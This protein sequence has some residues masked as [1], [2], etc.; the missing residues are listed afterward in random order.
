MAGTIARARLPV[1]FAGAGEPDP[2][3]R[4]R[5]T[6]RPDR[7]EAAIE[8]LPGVGPTIARRLARLGLETV[9]D[10]LWQRPR[11][12]EE[13][14]PAKRICDLFG[15]EEAV[16]EGVVRSAT[17]RR[18]GR[19]KIL[20][21]RVADGTGEIKATWFNQPWLESKLV[22]GTPV[23]VRGRA[24]RYGFAV[25][26]YDLDG[27]SET[28]DF[29]P[30]YPASEDVSQKKLRELRAHALEL[31]RDVGEL[32]PASLLGAE[33]L[34][35]RA[36]A[37]ASVH[38]P[39]TLAEAEMGR[40]RL[41][42]EELLVLR[43]ALARTASRRE[44]ASAVPL[45]APGELLARYRSS[46]PFTLTPDQERSIVEID[47]DLAPDDA[48]ATAAAGRGRL[49]QDG[50]RPLC[51]AARGGARTPG[52]AD[53]TDGDARRAALPH[54]R[55]ALRTA[56]RPGQPADELAAGEGARGREAGDRV[57]R[58]RHRRRH[59]RADRD[60]GR[61]RRPRRRRR[62]RAAP[63][64]RRAAERARRGPQP[65]RPA[66]HGDADPAHARTHRVR[67][68]RRQRAHAAAC[69]PQARDHGLGHR[70]A[71]LG[72][73]Q[74][75]ATTPRRRPP[76]LRRLPADRGVGDTPRASRR[77][78]SGTSAR[79]GATGVSRRLPARAPPTCGAARASWRASRRASWTSSSR[80]R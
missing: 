59:A 57:R 52:R 36:D 19:L 13:P 11:R 49:G 1:G 37:L 80:P 5:F 45:G 71:E 32:L 60:G 54:H 73:V 23:R 8:T 50:R 6:P 66:P 24:N 41:A 69:R 20:T 75:T 64:R 38:R 3:L 16:I 43:L 29:A 72:G 68:S 33:R 10:L 79:R 27:E 12:Y 44:Q 74:E 22:P 67:R 65:A 35:G 77:G 40:K 4:P 42:F 7:L 34:P 62:G 76:G 15:D 63:L 61:L 58:R 51:A 55:R 70:G 39:R 21:A 14:V 31:V 30:V 78:G 28:A 53:G 46:L 17:S 48:D 9:G 2:R 56:R 26:S 25:S 18:R 47:A